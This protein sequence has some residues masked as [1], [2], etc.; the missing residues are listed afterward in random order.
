MRNHVTALIWALSSA[1]FLNLTQAVSFPYNPASIFLSQS[2]ST[3]KGLVYAFLSIS[4]SNAQQQ[5]VSLNISS[6]LWTSNLSFQSISPNLPFTSDDT[7]AFTPSISSRD[8]IS[9]YTGSCQTSTSSELW[10]FTPSNTSNIG[11]GTWA[12]QMITAGSDVTSDTLP[13][14]D[15]LSRGFS[16]STLVNA[17]ASQTDIYL[18]GGMCPSTMA[19]ISTWQSAANY[20]NHMLRLAP[21]NASSNAA[22]TLDVATSKGPPIAEAGFTLTGLSPTYSN[23]TGVETQ[24]RTYVLLGGHTETAFINMSQVALWNLPEEGWSFITVDSPGT[25]SNTELAIKST[26]TSIDSRSGHT[27]VLTEDGSQIIV[28]GGWVGDVT[29]A[30]DPQLAILDLGAGFG[31]TGDWKW[32]VPTQQP[33]GTGI[34]GHGAVMLPGNVMMVLGGHNISATGTTKRAE[35]STP[36]MFFNVSSMQWTSIYTNPAYLAS[37][38]SSAPNSSSSSSKNVGLGVG[39]GLG[40]GA[41]VIALIIFICYSKRLKKHRQEQREKDINDLNARQAQAYATQNKEMGDR[42]PWSNRG[43]NGGGNDP[44]RQLY[45]SNSA[46]SGYENLNTG[47]HALGDSGDVPPPPKQIQRKPLHSRTAR[48]IYQPAPT[49]DFNNGG[50]HGRANSL[51]TAGP[52]HPIYEAD[53]EDHVSHHGTVEDAAVGVALG[54]PSVAGPSDSNR[55][56]DPF[57]DQNDS[58]TSTRHENRS[59]S[60]PD[61]SPAR[62]RERE[63]QEWVS[64]WAAADALMSAQSR[65][66]SN[67]GRL[68]PARRA[69]LIAG[70]TVSSISAEEDSGR[71]ASNLSERSVAVSAISRSGS[72]SQGRSRSNSLRGF[73]STAMNPFAS[74]VMSTTVGSTTITPTFDVPGRLNIPPRSAG[75]GTSSFTTAHTSF[76]ALQAEAETLLPRPEDRSGDENSPTREPSSPSKIRR[77]TGR[78]TRGQIGWLGSIRRVFVGEASS[79]NTSP[80]AASFSSREHSPVRIDG[81]SASDMAPRRTVSAGATLW[82]RKQGKSDWEDSADENLNLRGGSGGRS[83]TFTG[84]SLYSGSEGVRPGTSAGY[85]SAAMADDEDEDWDIERAVENRVVQVMFT[86]PKEKLRVVNHDFSE[87]NS[88]VGSLRSKKGSGKS[89]AGKEEEVPPLPPPHVETIVEETSS[90]GSGSPRPRTR[91]LE[92]VEKM[93]GRSSPTR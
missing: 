11:N 75:S 25:N 20:S 4:E 13:G 5:L 26:V 9:V 22:Y 1:L 15:F 35:P 66:H 51:G 54:D 46:I 33:S 24:Q 74:T 68:S 29:Q 61:E 49:F 14:A 84:D 64:D 52:I 79:G 88:E 77:N 57:R 90:Q 10:R 12:Q 38:V 8:E 55:R 89:V 28:L 3:D 40:L 76:G 17:N 27:A 43:W 39:L 7:A 81:P 58:P 80:G 72:S 91:V 70:S 82:R 30:A 56:S 86:V 2:S 42:F 59:V 60:T 63:I 65:I 93:E 69:Q 31:G 41:V 83:N 45:E 62:S 85:S 87:D 18:F 34:Y 71:T 92:M 37:L 67:A 47:V 73:I 36:A 48:G 6:T 78:N 19:N 16:F 23:S 53:E 21:T 44:E 50:T 32:T